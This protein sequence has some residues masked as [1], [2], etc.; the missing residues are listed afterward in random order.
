MTASCASVP[1][2]MPI[3]CLDP[4]VRGD[5]LL[6]GLDARA[7]DE[8]LALVDVGRRTKDLL[9]DRRVLLLQVE[10]RDGNGGR[11]HGGHGA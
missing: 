2:D 7:Q 1:E 10:E 4:D 11:G 3:A 6:E 9:A 5:R 8:L